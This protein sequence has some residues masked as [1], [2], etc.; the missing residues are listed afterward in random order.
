MLK[1]S[2]LYISVEGLRLIWKTKPCI[3]GWLGM[4]VLLQ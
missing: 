3:N 2:S 4:T 1:L